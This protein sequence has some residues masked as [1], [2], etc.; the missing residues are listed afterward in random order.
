MPRKNT[1]CASCQCPCCASANP[2]RESPRCCIAGATADLIA[3]C[4]PRSRYSSASASKPYS[5]IADHVVLQERH[6]DVPRVVPCLPRNLMSSRGSSAAA[7]T[8]DSLQQRL[9][10]LG[11]TAACLWWYSVGNKPIIG[12][13]NVQPGCICSSR[14]SV[15]Q[16]MGTPGPTGNTRRARCASPPR[17]ER[18]HQARDA[19]CLRSFGARRRRG[20][21]ASPWSFL[22][23][24]VPTGRGGGFGGRPAALGVRRS[25]VGLSR[26]R[27][28]PP[29]AF[30]F[31]GGVRHARAVGRQL[32]R[33]SSAS[34]R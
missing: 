23:R 17:A 4:S 24:R 33:S 20:G 27:G 15:A 6:G 19:Q 21:R 7:A 8:V 18:A 14:L 34:V 2:T 1:S 25:R 13:L 3:S 10:P 30:A 26:R 12:K 31:G 11:R 9:H 29:R 5:C 32:T 22:V 28:S 16:T